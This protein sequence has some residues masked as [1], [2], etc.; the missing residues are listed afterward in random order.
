MRIP[1]GYNVGCIAGRNFAN[2]MS[3]SYELGFWFSLVFR[4]DIGRFSTAAIEWAAS[5]V[6]EIDQSD[7]LGLSRRFADGIERD[8]YAWRRF[9]LM[10]R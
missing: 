3:S 8:I 4:N 7:I 10:R 9:R 1:G 2:T 5:V 6:L